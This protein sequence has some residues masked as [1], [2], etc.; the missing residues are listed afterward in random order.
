MYV[1]IIKA[2]TNPFFKK[3]WQN[4]PIQL[5]AKQNVWPFADHAKSYAFSTLGQAPTFS[6]KK[7]LGPLQLILPWTDT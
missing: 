5:P 4:L 6:D 7:T 2:V 1:Y 3:L